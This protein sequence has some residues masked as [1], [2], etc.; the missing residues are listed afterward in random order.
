MK[1]ENTLFLIIVI[2][3]VKLAH[4]SW[5]Q[6]ASSDSTFLSRMLQ[7]K[8]SLGLEWTTFLL[9]FADFPVIIYILM[10]LSDPDD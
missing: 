4:N 1:S 9:P 6:L 2:P 8:E 10:M 7:T 5:L 3:S